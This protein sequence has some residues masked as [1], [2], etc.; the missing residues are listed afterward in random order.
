LDLFVH[1][2]LPKIKEQVSQFIKPSL[3]QQCS[4]SLMC[5]RMMVGAQ[6]QRHSAHL[7]VPTARP[8]AGMMV[9][10]Q[11]HSAHLL[12]PTARPYASMMVGAQRHSAHL[13]IPT[14]RPSSQR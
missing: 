14:A 8:Y 1:V 6:R 11:R 7:L 12:I 13:L 9:G 2:V 5:A 10:A 4:Q 3:V